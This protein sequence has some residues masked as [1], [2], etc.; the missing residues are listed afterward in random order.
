LYAEVASTFKNQFASEMSAQSEE[1]QEK[2]LTKLNGELPAVQKVL[3]NNIHQMLAPEMARLESDLRKEF[4]AE[5]R[6][7]LESVKFVLP[8]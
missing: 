3:Q 7:L 2:Y 4:T 5:I 8:K 1:M 6:G